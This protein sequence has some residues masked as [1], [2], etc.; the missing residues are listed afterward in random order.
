MLDRQDK[1]T[2]LSFAAPQVSQA[3]NNELHVLG[4]WWVGVAVQPEPS[5]PKGHQQS[6]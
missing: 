5:M 2:N 3:F 1:T 4:G 6:P